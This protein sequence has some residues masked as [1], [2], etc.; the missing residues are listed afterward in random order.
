M[1]LGFVW[2]DQTE[3]LGSGHG[4]VE[5]IFL[6]I[7]YLPARNRREEKVGRRTRVKKRVRLASDTTSKGVNQNVSLLPVGDCVKIV[8]CGKI[9]ASLERIK[10]E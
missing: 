8:P 6:S 1:S 10:E 7:I 2:H 9:W 4:H 5:M 3:L